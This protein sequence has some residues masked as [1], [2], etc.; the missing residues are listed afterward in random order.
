MGPYVEKY[1]TLTTMAAILNLQSLDGA[2]RGEEAFTDALQ[3]VVIQRQ[4]VQVLQ[5]LEGIH[6]QTVDLVGVQ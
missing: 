6:S 5:V 2:Q 1:I 4:E 3:L